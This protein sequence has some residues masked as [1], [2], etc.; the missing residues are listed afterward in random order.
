MHVIKIK[1]FHTQQTPLQRWRY[2][3][4]RDKFGGR[5]REEGSGPGYSLKLQRRAVHSLSV[6]DTFCRSLRR[7]GQRTCSC[8]LPTVWFQLQPL[9]IRSVTKRNSADGKDKG[10]KDCLVCCAHR[11]LCTPLIMCVKG[12]WSEDLIIKHSRTGQPHRSALPRARRTMTGK[13]R[14]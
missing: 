5:G 6:K 9:R 2:I 3:R 14:S 11:L 10:R 1:G 13:A 12:R 7:T 4:L 8:R